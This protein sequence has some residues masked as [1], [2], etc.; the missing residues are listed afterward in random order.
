MN[1]LRPRLDR[2]V[3]GFGRDGQ[4]LLLLL[5]A[6][7]CIALPLFTHLPAWAAAVAATAF[8]AKVWLVR[9]R[10]A[11]PG[12][13]LLT[14]ITAA[15]TAATLLQFGTLLGRD[16]GVTLLVVLLCVKLLELRARRDTFVVICLGFFV[17]LCQF[18]YSQSIPTAGLVALGVVA[19]LT[20]QV[21]QNLD[22][23]PACDAPP[24]MRVALGIALRI[25]VF[26]LPLMLAL[27]VLFPRA[28]G[29]L[30]GRP[31]AGFA[32]TGMSD[33][34]APGSI[35]SLAQSDEIA[36]RVHFDGAAPP[37][38]AR[39]FRALVLGSFDGRTWRV[40]GRRAA[41]AAPEP[42]VEARGAT[43]TY[44]ITQEPQDQPWLYLLD[45]PV[46][47]PRVAGTRTGE[48]VRAT[49][50]STYMT[51]LRQQQRI[52][53]R[54][55]SA[56]AYRLAPAETT[57]TLDTWIELPPSFNP[58]TLE[59]AAAL[60]RETDDPQ[61]LL[62]RVLA[63]FRE[64]AYRYTLQP[65]P[66]GRN[67]VDE[68]LF[69]TRA[70]FCEHYASAFVVLMRALDIPARVVAGYQG[71]EINSAD[72]ALELRQRDAH[73]WA[74]VWLG[75]DAGWVRVD[76]TAAVAPERVEAG[77]GRALPRAAFAG[78]FT[79]AP[80][81]T[82]MSAM[83]S[84]RD[85]WN[86][87]EGA[88]NQWV[89]QY[90]ATAQ[91]SLFQRLGFKEP[92]WRNL[93][94]AALIAFAAISAALAARILWRS[95]RHDPLLRSFARFEARL[96]RAGIVREPHETPLAFGARLQRDLD[97]YTAVRANRIVDAFVALRYR[98]LP[99][100]AAP[101]TPTP[102]ELHRW[103]SEFRVPSRS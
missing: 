79:L 2:Y 91:R 99:G 45:A 90:N 80:D 88:W 21:A 69:D 86:A 10:R 102:A 97:K 60:R 89:L 77:I 52:L 78:V 103:I 66:L 76:P 18:L 98:A 13:W 74:E 73:A 62:R 41:P 15:L 44:T 3:A 47:A 87:I 50:E 43:L 85:R 59:L 7:A 22:G 57:A 49:P 14:M 70:G 39:Y 33:T 29:P 58:R 20:A 83:R 27:F 34:M 72:G 63:M 92:N 9:A 24:T 67:S 26:A 38:A 31:D 46:R 101:A 94:L 53:V 82:L 30:W 71:G 65:P 56:T 8:A 64:Q 12:R 16:A 23:D 75:A 96:A 48:T 32:G 68:F 93:M 51:P 4:Q 95:P 5:I 25:L 35:T 1:A 28:T 84:L 36:F 81:N 40:L 19:L 37:P 61:A 42:K 6:V 55:E 17:A 54:A 100:A 11:V